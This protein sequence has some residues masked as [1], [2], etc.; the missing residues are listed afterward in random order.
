MLYQYIRTFDADDGTLTDLSLDNQDESSTLPFDLVVSE[1]YYYIAQFFPFNNFFV[2]IDT[3]NDVTASITL[4]Y[5]DGTSW[6]EA[7]DVLDG[8]S[9]SGV[10]FKELFHLIEDNKNVKNLSASLELERVKNKDLKRKNENLE[11][12]IIILKSAF[13]N[14]QE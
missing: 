12:E 4:E 8:T 3:A 14:I 10:S 9:T 13:K 2:Q 7:V 11:N 6:R 5:Y 1:D